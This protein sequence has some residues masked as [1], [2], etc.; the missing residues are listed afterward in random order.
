MS[1]YFAKFFVYF[2]RY[3]SENFGCKFLLPENNH[4]LNKVIK[5]EACE[6]CGFLSKD[7]LDRITQICIS[8]MQVPI[9]SYVDQIDD[10]LQKI[11]LKIV[12]ETAKFPD[13]RQ[14][15]EEMLTNFVEKQLKKCKENIKHL[16]N[17]E[18]ATFEVDDEGL[19]A[20]RKKHEKRSS[21]MLSL[22]RKK[23]K[24]VVSIRILYD[25]FPITKFIFKF[26]FR[27]NLFSF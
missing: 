17:V 18:Y 7:G 25:L 23:K 21:G 14:K 11:V 5:I 19:L 9:L 10:L 3:S 20:F 1:N 8:K 13:L 15:L 12:Q 27:T 22:F 24:I 2:F 16:V 6:P 4:L 26:H